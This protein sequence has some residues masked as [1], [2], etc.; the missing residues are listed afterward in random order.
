MACFTL[1]DADDLIY[2]KVEVVGSNPIARSILFKAL[3]SF[4]A[5]G[6]IVGSRLSHLCHT[7][8]II[9][10][11]QLENETV[12]GRFKS[13]EKRQAEQIRQVQRDIET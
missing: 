12:N 11:L 1:L 2:A 7:G 8:N 3:A 4:S 10:W 13:V 9:R 5:F 6:T